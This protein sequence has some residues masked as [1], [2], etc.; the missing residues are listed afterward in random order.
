MLQYCKPV[1]DAKQIRTDELD[2]SKPQQFRKQS[3]RARKQPTSFGYMVDPTR[4][5]IDIDAE[6]AAAS[7]AA[8]AASN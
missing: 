7:A 8:A 3:N 5:E 1:R 2:L 6:P 4:I